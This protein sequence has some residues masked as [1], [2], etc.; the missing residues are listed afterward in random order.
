MSELTLPLPQP[1]LF[2]SPLAR[3]LPV[4]YQAAFTQ[5]A[6]DN[7]AHPLLRASARD[8][9]PFEGVISEAEGEAQ[10]DSIYTIA[11]RRAVNQLSHL[12]KL[13]SSGTM[14]STT[15]MD[16]NAKWERIKQFRMKLDY[17]ALCKLSFNAAG[18]HT[19]LI[20]DGL[21]GVPGGMASKAEGYK[22]HDKFTAPGRSKRIVRVEVEAEETLRS[23]F[24]SSADD[25]FDLLS[26]FEVL[27]KKKLSNLA[28]SSDV[29]GFKSIVCY[30]TGLDV[31]LSSAEK[32][33]EDA[34]EELWKSYH[35]NDGRIRLAHKVL[36]D[37]VVRIA[38]TVAGEK[39]IPVQ[40][41]TGLGD[42]DIRLTHSSPAH[43]QPLIERYPGTNFVILHASYPYTRDA[44][45]LA[46]VY[47]NVY[48]DFGEVFPFVS[49]SGQRDVIRQMLE[50]T[51]TNKIL[52]S[53]DGHWW[54]E[55]YYLGIY[56]A[57]LA[58]FD[59]L[60][61]IVI[62]EELDEGAAV[63]IVQDALYFNSEKL[64]RL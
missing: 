45:Y 15:S 39:G 51:P 38:L 44:G 53:S 31:S 50:L 33:K 27:F 20:D 26:K 46:A 59:V 36:N 22:W 23:I 55:S 40:F 61:D 62:R 47:K 60:A 54:P 56:Q 16:E 17:D 10:A 43:M 18:I 5:P 7:H 37:E 49:S 8:V 30:R 28:D 34:I 14:P 24:A 3:R 25:D 48:L 11:A 41:H 64:Y 52:W 4:L 29:V 57:R 63:K 2:L 19:I 32:E 9:L 6:I 1:S 12:F 35:S 42:T 13:D 21:G 58:L